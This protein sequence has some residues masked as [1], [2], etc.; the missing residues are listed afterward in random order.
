MDLLFPNPRARGADPQ[1]C[2]V[3]VSRLLR[4]IHEELFDPLLSVQSLKSHC[5]TQDHNVSSRFRREVGT[6][7]KT[8]IE[9]L[10]MEAAA[11]WLIET[12][13]SIF[14]ISHQL[15]YEHP[16][17]FYRVFRRHFNRAPGDYRSL[18]RQEAG[19]TRTESRGDQ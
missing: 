10:R 5:G 14:D 11:V 13:A 9:T 8:Y 4:T 17:T 3:Y 18:M 6:S 7:I 1:R 16:Q 12:D 15:G 19:Q 2:S